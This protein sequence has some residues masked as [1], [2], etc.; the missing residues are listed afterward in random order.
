MS[1]KKS[2][3]LKDPLN[4]KSRRDAELILTHLQKYLK[5]TEIS[6]TAVQQVSLKTKNFPPKL[7]QKLIKEYWDTTMFS[8]Y[9]N[10]TA[11]RKAKIVYN[12]AF[13]SAIQFYK[14]KRLLHPLLWFPG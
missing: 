5:L 1:K 10:P 14:E 6:N 2:E 3:I 11:L 9:F 4:R 13:L 7:I 8:S 12:L